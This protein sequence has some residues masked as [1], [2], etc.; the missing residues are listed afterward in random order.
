MSYRA[1]NDVTSALA[2]FVESQIKLAVP[3]ASVS[4]LPPGDTLPQDTGINLYLYRVHEC[5][6]TRNDPW[7]GD[8][9]HPP[10]DTP[11]LGL[12]LHYLLTP[13]GK[14][15]E[16]NAQAGDV[17]HT[18]LGIAMLAL[19]EHPVLN[20]IHIP[21]FDAD[22]I[23]STALLDSYEDIKVI[24]SPVTVEDLSKIWA[25]INQPYR[26]SVAYEVSLVEL[27]PDRKS[28]VIAGIVQETNLTVFTLD[29]PRLTGLNP[30]SGALARVAAGVVTA[31][32]LT[33]TGSGLGR[34]DVQPIVRIGG[35]VV[36]LASPAA[37]PFTSLT[38]TLPTSLDAG[39][40]ADV[41]VSVAGKISQ[42]ATF[43]VSPW[44]ASI[45]PL[46]TALD[47][48]SPTITL[49]GHE[50]TATPQV[51]YEGPAGIRT[52]TAA[53]AAGVLRAP[54]PTDLTNGVY[55]VRAQLGGGQLS[56]GRTLEVIPNVAG[57]PTVTVTGGKHQIALAGARL[58]GSQIA[59]IVDGVPYQ[60]PAN[61]NATALTFTFQRLLPAGEHTVA[62]DVDGSRS[63]TVPF[64]VT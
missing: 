25:T 37:A 16:A 47:T 59:L 24:L 64:T 35:N 22:V 54:I 50:L 57:A 1:I 20:D 18:L 23:L 21:G 45:T 4:L 43:T 3:T 29:P 61:A 26:L 28:P 11:P 17:A 15:S 7:R 2:T 34:L 9:T 36:D 13:L 46:R 31:N 19:H 60:L 12:Q 33:I 32:T 39:P 6:F 48:A 10:L 55:D 8:R 40:Q 27:V 41:R 53:T 44:L 56:N 51:R 52:V 38:V 5:P 49:T 58:A 30:A 62:V 63:H 42:P 14:K